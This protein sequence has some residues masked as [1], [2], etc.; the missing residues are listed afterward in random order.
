MNK[1]EFDNFRKEPV[2]WLKVAED[3]N[4]LMRKPL[5]DLSLWA[6]VSRAFKFGLE[7]YGGT[8]VIAPTP[9]PPCRPFLSREAK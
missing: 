5:K 8:H 7:H 1:R 4:Y 3:L 9:T 6:D 2:Q